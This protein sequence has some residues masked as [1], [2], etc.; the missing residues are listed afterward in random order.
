VDPRPSPIAV[1]IERIRVRLGI[2]LAAI[3]LVSLPVAYGNQVAPPTEKV[4]AD[5]TV[6]SQTGKTGA[7]LR[8]SIRADRGSN[9]AGKSNHSKKRTL[10]VPSTEAERP[11]LPVAAY[12][13]HQ[14]GDHQ[15]A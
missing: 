4:P 13:G 8:I 15:F 12:G 7:Q 11:E 2:V 10:G 3:I 1:D 6:Q 14:N 5:R 9:W